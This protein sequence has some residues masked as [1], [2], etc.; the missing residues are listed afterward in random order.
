MFNILAKQF[1][2]PQGLLGKLAGKIMYAEN[3]TINAWTFKKLNIKNKDRILEV[4]YGPGYGIKYVMNRCRCVYMD[5]ADLSSDM[6]EQ[7]GKRNKEWIEEGRVRLF[8]GDIHS[9]ASDLDTYHKI[10]SINN[11]PLWTKPR[12]TLGMLYEIT[13]PGGDI[14]ITVQPREKGADSLITKDLAKIIEA[15]LSAAG[16]EEIQTSFKDVRPVPAVCVTAKKGRQ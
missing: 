16:Y 10:I 15:D 12:E 7:A 14:A 1:E 9:L 6:A 5:G 4:G 2:N 13:E 8:T 11:Y 3:R